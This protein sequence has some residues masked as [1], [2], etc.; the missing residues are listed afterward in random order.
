[1]DSISIGSNSGSS[2]AGEVDSAFLFGFSSHLL[3]ALSLWPSIIEI[4]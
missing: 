4:I 2:W 1:M 3:F